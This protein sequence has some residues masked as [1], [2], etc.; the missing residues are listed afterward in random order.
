MT[1]ALIGW[2]KEG[3]LFSGLN[4]TI[5]TVATIDIAHS[6]A[7][8][9][10]VAKNFSGA[11]QMLPSVSRMSVVEPLYS[12]ATYPGLG[13]LQRPLD[14]AR[15][16]HQEMMSGAIDTTRMIYIAGYNRRTANG[17]S[18]FARLNDLHS[19]TMT[20]RGD[21]TVP[22]SLGL[23]DGV[24][25]FYV[26]EE[27]SKLPS[28]PNVLQAMN[29]LLSTGA[30]AEPLLWH[31]LSPNIPA[32]VLGPEA[33]DLQDA[34]LREMETHQRDVQALRDSLR[35]RGVV[36]ATTTPTIITPEESRL[37]T[38]CSAA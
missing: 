8:L 22:H 31:G 30:V 35:T 17:I 34:S 11:W 14:D 3:H 13:A 7:D 23:L 10:Q 25:A 27:H 32:L 29:S 33:T 28:N 18:D 37:Q 15:R 9:L 1:L 38:I 12:A 2:V 4:D 16:L 19:Y 5:K 20:M 21:G 36:S 6:T 24:T 26:D